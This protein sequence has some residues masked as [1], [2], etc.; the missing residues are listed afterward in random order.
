MGKH[1]QKGKHHND[2]DPYDDDYVFVDEL[3]SDE[4]AKDIF[5]TDW[6]SN[7]KAPEPTDARRR[8]E[9]REETKRLYYQL[10][11]WEEFGARESHHIY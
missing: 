6:E 2:F 1:A 10:D 9:Q 8:I 3:G 5:S 4:L 7:S 11:D